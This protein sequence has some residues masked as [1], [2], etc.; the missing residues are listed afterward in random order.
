MAE[1]EVR[2]RFDAAPE[3]V[4]DA[5]TNPDVLRRWFAARPDW[6]T[7]A[8]EVDLRPGGRYRL[9]MRDTGQD[10]TRTVVGEF[11]EIDRPGRLVYTWAWEHSDDT[12]TLVVVEFRPDGDGTEVVLTHSGFA[13]PDTR[14][15]HR[16]GW[17]GCLDNLDARVIAVR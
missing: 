14:D 9:A 4:F 1:L 8:A 16:H 13:D 12:E 6:D 2:R 5:W 15:D 7:P 10:M 11:T 3:R 17:G